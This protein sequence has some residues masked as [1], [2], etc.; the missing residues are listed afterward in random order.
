MLT[1]AFS[2]SHQLFQSPLSQGMLLACALLCRGQVSMS[3]VQHNIDRLKAN[4]KFVPWNEEGWKIGL[5]NVPHIGCRSSVLM[6]ANTSSITHSLCL[7][8][9]N[10]MKMYRKKAHLHHFLEVECMEKDI[11]RASLNDLI[12]LIQ[13]YKNVEKVQG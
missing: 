12:L 5:C 2:V 3:D 9:E 10:F 1:E 7:L 4:L 11:F 13:E 8:Q 6:L